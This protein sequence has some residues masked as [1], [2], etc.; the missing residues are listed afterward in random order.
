VETVSAKKEIPSF[1]AVPRHAAPP[2]VPLR[3]S[4]ATIIK[5]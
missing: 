1:D 5:P 2:L 3:I 4:A